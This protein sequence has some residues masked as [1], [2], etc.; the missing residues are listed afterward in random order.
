LPAILELAVGGG[1]MV[2]VYGAVLLF[3]LNQRHFYLDLIRGLKSRP[4][5]ES[6]GPAE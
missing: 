3:A 1:A 4:S 6:Y 2:L 5:S